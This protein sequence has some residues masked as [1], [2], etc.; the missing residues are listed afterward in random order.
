M[1]HGVLKPLALSEICSAHPTSGGPY[2]WAAMLSEPKHAPFASWI[3]GWFNLLGQV[4][5]T[6]GI[7]SVALYRKFKDLTLSRLVSTSLASRVIFSTMK[8]CMCN[9]HFHCCHIWDKFRSKPKQK[10]W[11]L[12][13]CCDCARWVDSEK[14]AIHYD[15]FSMSRSYQHIWRPHAEI[16]QQY[17]DMVACYRDNCSCNCN[18]KRCSDTPVCAFRIC[19]IYRWYGGRRCRVECPSKSRLCG[20]NWNFDSTVHINR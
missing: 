18:S 2:F 20:S 19:Y 17:L 5:V 13:C 3:T 16:Y 10:H 14:I 1:V 9:I 11:R 12:C 8:L 7:R 6:T 15:P 4:A